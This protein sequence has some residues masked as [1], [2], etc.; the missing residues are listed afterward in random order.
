MIN[1]V[2][3]R[4]EVLAVSEGMLDPDRPVGAESRK[5]YPVKIASGFFDRYLSGKAILDI[6]YK[7]GLDGVVPIVPQAIGID[8]DYPGYDGKKLP[9]PDESQDAVYSSHCLEHIKDY[10]NAIREWFRVV[11]ISGYL[12]IIVPHQHLFERKRDLPSRNNRDHKRFYTPANL[13]REVE[14][15]LPEPN[16]YRIRHLMDN[17]LGFDYS[18]TPLQAGVGCFEIELVLQKIK[19][20]AW[21]LDDGVSRTYSAAEFST[22]LERKHSFFLETDFSLTDA[23]PIYGP[24]VPLAAGNYEVKYF[25]EAMGIEDQELTS[26]ITLDVAQDVGR[27][28]ITSITLLGAE[29]N[30]VIRDGTVSLRFANDTPESLFEFRIF[31]SGR[32][33]R[34]TLRFYGVWLERLW[35]TL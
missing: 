4:V 1:A 29:G 16:S 24:Y 22:H 28:R 2:D 11:K 12:V 31:T 6:G 35:P 25:F 14:E 26:E 7:G 32:P 27:R 30:R 8:V 23:C 13:L 9:F 5:T 10:R 34:G 20:P 33:F 17:D 21:D 19:K 18:I 3:R 15:A